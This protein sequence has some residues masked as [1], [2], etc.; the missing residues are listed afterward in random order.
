MNKLFTTLLCSLFFFACG[1]D[2]K[3]ENSSSTTPPTAAIVEE[4]LNEL[5]P[6]LPLEKAERLFT[7]TDYLDYVF[8]ELPFS[9]N[10]SKEADI[11]NSIRYIST[12]PV[13]NRIPQ[14]KSIGR[15]F[16]QAKGE[17]IGE[18]EFHFNNDVGCYYLIFM[19][20]N[21]PKYANLLTQTGVTNYS[22][23]F[24]QVQQ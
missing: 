17:I 24:S 19:E 20:E 3:T 1:S 12:S 22:N 23:L 15:I 4:P 11:K 18:A 6:T 5:Y 9:M 16:Y 7:E 8:Y 14:C 21:K 10:H 13:T 2:T